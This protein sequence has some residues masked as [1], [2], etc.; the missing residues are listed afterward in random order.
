[1]LLNLMTIL[2]KN[3][4]INDK[5]IVF[6]SRMKVMLY[7]KKNKLNIEY[8]L[9]ITMKMINFEQF[10]IQSNISKKCILTALGFLLRLK[11]T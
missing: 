11:G 10:H 3:K 7:L 5:I 4:F 8:S 2:N 1:M 9:V 6:I